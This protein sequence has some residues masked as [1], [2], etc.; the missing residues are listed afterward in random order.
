MSNA[1]TASWPPLKR[2]TNG[3]KMTKTN[4][5]DLSN[6]IRTADRDIAQAPAQPSWMETW[7]FPVYSGL[8]EIV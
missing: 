2:N 5:D 1:R 3:E 4:V 7:A 6:E 8:S